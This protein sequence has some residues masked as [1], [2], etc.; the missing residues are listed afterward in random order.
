MNIHSPEL[1]TS[2]IEERVLGYDLV[3]GPFE[4]DDDKNSPLL[5]GDSLDP[6]LIIHSDFYTNTFQ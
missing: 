4:F 2:L 5:F 3:F 6:D 1:L